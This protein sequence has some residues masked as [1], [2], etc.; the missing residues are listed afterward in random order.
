MGD[1][2]V[3]APDGALVTRVLYAVKFNVMTNVFLPTSS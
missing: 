1:I 2:M 3:L